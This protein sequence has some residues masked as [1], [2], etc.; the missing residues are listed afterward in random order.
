MQIIPL[1]GHSIEQVGLWYGNTLFVGDAYL[2]PEILDK[3]HIPFYTDILAGL[4]TLDLLKALVKN[5]EESSPDTL[6]LSNGNI[7]NTKT[8]PFKHVVAGHGELYS[9]SDKIHQVIDYSVQR[10]ESILEQVRNSLDYGEARSTADVL[11]SVAAIQSAAIT[12]LS[13]HALYNT[14]VQAALS[15]LYTQDAIHPI[16]QDN[17]LLWQRTQ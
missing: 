7:L 9:L 5:S 15:A 10:L 17:R 6:T 14:T 11:S 4:K 1:P 2:T 8:T 13:Q 12:S 16:F 3:H